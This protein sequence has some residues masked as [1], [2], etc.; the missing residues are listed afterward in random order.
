MAETWII[1]GANRGMGLEYARQ[2]L[3]AGN[4]VIATARDPQGAGDLQALATEFP[5]LLRI[6]QMDAGNDASIAAFAARLGGEAVDVLLNN[7]GISRAPWPDGKQIHPAEL[8]YGAWE[9][10]LRVNLFAPFAL[11]L[12][13]RP[14]LA[15]GA[16]KLVVM[17]SSDLGSIAANTMGGSYAYRA[18]KA[19][20]NMVTKGLSIDLKVDG[21]AVVSMA[22]G[23]VRTDLGGAAAHWSVQDS[24]ANQRKVIAGLSAADTGR[25]INLLGEP[26]GW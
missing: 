10:T 23:W 4:R 7:A 19:G 17:M 15:A 16:R 1:T 21:I 13:L 20:L 24:V 26:V 14:N 2:C 11:T 25:F 3:A 12:A 6:E 5:A 18:S 8:D 9:A 22:P